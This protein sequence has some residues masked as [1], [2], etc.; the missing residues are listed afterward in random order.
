MQEPS[1]PP[2][3]PGFARRDLTEG[4]IIRNLWTLSWPMLINNTLNA[5]GPTID[6]IWV[7]TLG[8]SAI[9]GVGISGLAVMVINS[10]ITGLFTGTIALIAW[11][12]GAKDEQSA[13]RAAQ[14]AFVISLAFSIVIALVGI[15][16]SVPFLRALGVDPAVVEEGAAYLRIQ[17]IGIITMTTLQA[18]QSIIQAS[19]DAVQPLLISVGYRILQVILCPALVFGWGFLPQLGVSGASL[20]NVITQGLGG[21]VAVY[22]L[23]S[24]RTRIRVTFKNFRFDGNMIWRTV[25]IG[26][27]ASFSFMQRNIAELILMWFITPFGTL[28]VAAQ[29]VSQRVDQFLQNLSG[30]LG[31]AAGIVA[32]QNMGAGRPDRAGKTGWLAA[33]LAT[34]V[35]FVCIIVIWLWINPILSIFTQDPEVLNMAANFLRIS[36]VSYLVWGLVVSL[37]L[38]LNG[39]G[40]TM[41]QMLTNLATMVLVQL[42][43]AYFLPRYTDLGVYGIRWA[44]VIGI[45]IRAIIYTAYFKAG[46]WKNRKF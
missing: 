46:R 2:A 45:V 43:L 37:S 4:S 34:A 14:Q 8:A 41:V 20:S 29:S 33:I 39:V 35:S 28:A 18:A 10:L 25:K 42:T 22:L 19:G 11:N 24:G 23:V 40:D 36:T 15:F 13:N 32:A 27:P 30:G 12:I 44:V 1:N 31:G 6:M 3:K 7:G 5:L 16:L 9:A 17:L 38:V 26:I 21:I